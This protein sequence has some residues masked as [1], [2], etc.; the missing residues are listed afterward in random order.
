[1]SFTY[2]G[3]PLSI[4]KSTVQERLPMVHR[5]EGRLISTSNFLSHRGKLQ[6]VN[7]VLSS[8]AT[9]YMCSIKVPISI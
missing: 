8:P 4:N 9:F 5:D 3:L 7:S 1:M 6:M 2:L